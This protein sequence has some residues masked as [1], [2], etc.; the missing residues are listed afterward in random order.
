MTD[1]SKYIDSPSCQCD[2]C[3]SMCT[4]PCWGT[5][6]E[7]EAIIDAGLWGNLMLDYWIGDKYDIYIPCGASPGRECKVAGSWPTGVCAFFKNGG[8]SLHAA[9][10]KPIEGRVAHHDEGINPPGIHE[11]VAMAWD[12]PEGHRVVDRVRRLFETVDTDE[13]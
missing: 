11:K 12:T 3:N 13:D 10:L 8:C 7:I 9:G 6:A 5:P 4:R 2:I 1:F